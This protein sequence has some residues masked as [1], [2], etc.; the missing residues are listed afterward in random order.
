MFK[1]YLKIAFRN[2][3]RKKGFSLINISG[4]A[5][6]MACCLLI[7]LYVSD[8]LSFDRFHENGDRIYRILS[9]STIG[10]TT[11]HFAIS[12]S[13][14]APAAAE[15]I[16]EIKLYSRLYEFGGM[17]LQQD[18]DIHEFPTWYAADQDFF[19]IFSHNFIMGNPNTALQ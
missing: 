17:R 9:Y 13:A 3:Q 16:P 14:L 6:G 4:L 18:D 8:E 2:L 10:G 7:L 5:I 15:S 12:P 11:R 19:S 1:N